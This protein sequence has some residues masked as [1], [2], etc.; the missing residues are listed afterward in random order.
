MP[1]GRGAGPN[2]GQPA[3]PL[4]QGAATGGGRGDSR[5]SSIAPTDRLIRVKG[6]AYLVPVDATKDEIIQHLGAP[7]DPP[8]SNTQTFL[9]THPTIRSLLDFAPDIPSMALGGYALKNIIAQPIKALANFGVRKAVPGATT[10]QADI[11]LRRGAA[12]LLKRSVTKLPGKD[13][14]NT[15]NLLENAIDNRM[16]GPVSAADLALAGLGYAV[17]GSIPLAVAKFA[18]RPLPLSILSQAAHSGAGAGGAA[19]GAGG[20]GL[21]QEILQGLLGGGG[22]K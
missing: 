17:P 11:L 3:R 14:Q 15:R 21:A 10:H 4:N 1:Q 2:T 16:G 22:R 13:F 18:A 6:E 7:E 5:G 20:G 9:N 19:A 8:E 12:P